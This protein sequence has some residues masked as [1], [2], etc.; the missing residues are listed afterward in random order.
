M[1][2]KQK[3]WIKQYKDEAPENN[4][5]HIGQMGQEELQ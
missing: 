1:K 5:L 4:K 2:Q 3:K